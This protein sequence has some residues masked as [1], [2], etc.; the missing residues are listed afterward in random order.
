MSDLKVNEV[1]TDTIKDQ[2]GTTAMTIDSTGRILTPARPSFHA[3]KSSSSGSEGFQGIIVFDEEDFDIGSNYNTSNGRF[4]A[5]VAGIYWFCFD[6]LVSTNSVGNTLG[7]NEYVAVQFH[8]NGSNGTF[9]QR[10]YYKTVGATQFNTIHRVDCIQLAAND[11][12]QVN[13]LNEFI[14]SDNSGNY[15][16]TFQGYLIG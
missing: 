16:A 6:S 8:K 10:S 11:Y 15:D 9:S 14:Y 4:T 13:V 7:D 3:R 2:S 5:P 1:K 12:V